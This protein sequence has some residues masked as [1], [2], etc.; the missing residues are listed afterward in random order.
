LAISVILPVK[1]LV[2]CPCGAGLQAMTK[3][4]INPISPRFRQDIV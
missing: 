4:S 2:A 3:T 1:V